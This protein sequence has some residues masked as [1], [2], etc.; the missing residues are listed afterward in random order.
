[1]PFLGKETEAEKHEAFEDAVGGV[2]KA[3]QMQRLWNDSYPC[4]TKYDKTFK[5][6]F[7]RS[8]EQVFWIKAKREGF[9]QEQIDMFLSL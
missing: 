9:T 2:S 7:Y 3:E 8:K 4:G 1:M 6:G 5:T